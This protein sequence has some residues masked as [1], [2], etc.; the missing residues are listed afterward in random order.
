MNTSPRT[1]YL[2]VALLVLILSF[3]GRAFAEYAADDLV[4]AYALLKHAKGDYAGHR[5]K[6]MKEIEAVAKDMAIDL[7]GGKSEH[8]SQL[9]SD[10]QLKEA[11]RLLND[12]QDKLKAHNRDKAAENVHKAINEID[13][14]LKVK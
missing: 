5:A 9:K 4:Q 1:S 13:D 6:A 12:A 14:A 8:E 11:R 7:K 3:A 2:R 10:E